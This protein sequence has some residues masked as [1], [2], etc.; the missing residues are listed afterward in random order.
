MMTFIDGSLWRRVSVG[1]ALVLA[2]GGLVP[3]SAAVASDAV[4]PV[5]VDA[6]AGSTGLSVYD[7]SQGHS[8]TVTVTA[9]QPGTCLR[10][11]RL[12]RIGGSTTIT[13][14]AGKPLVRTGS[15]LLDA[16]Y[17]LAVQEAG[18]DSTEHVT[19]GDY[20]NGADMD[21][22]ADGTGCF[23]TGKNWT[24]I[25]TRD[26]SYSA[27]LG[28]SALDPVRM[29][30]TLE[31]R[32]SDR[33]TGWYDEA[34]DPQILQDSGTGGGYPNSTD[35]VSWATGAA[36]V[37]N[38]LPD[39]YRDAFAATSYTALSNTIDH[40]RQVVFDT[41]NQLYSG[42][43]SFLDWRW[44]TYPSWIGLDMTQIAQSMSLS[45]NVTHWIAIDQAATL[46]ARAGDAAKATRYRTWADDLAEAIRT[47]FWLPE[48]GQFSA[49]V[50]GTLDPA[51]TER[52]DA[53]GTALVILSG[54][55]TPQQAAQA[56]ASY[57]QTSS[58]APV[59]WPQQSSIW[60]NRSQLSYHNNAAWPFVTAFLLEAAAKVGNDTAAS[61][62]V[63]ALVRTPA[64]YGSNYE[65]VNIVGGGLNTDTNS[66]RQL[67]SVAG[68]LGSFQKT[69]F[70]VDASA[71]GLTVEPYLTAQTRQKY[72]PDSDKI[73]LEGLS[74][75]GRTVDVEVALPG[76]AATAGSYQVTGLTVNG[77]AV[78]P[79]AVISPAALGA[80]GAHATVAVTLGAPTAS[81]PATATAAVEVGNQEAQYGPDVPTVSTVTA[82]SATT[83]NLG[84]DLGGNSPSQVSMDVLRDGTVIADDVPASTGYADTTA[85][86]MASHSYCYSVRLTYRSSGNTSQPAKATC[87]WGPGGERILVADSSEFVDKVGGEWSDKTINGVTH[88]YVKDW[89]NGLNDSLTSRLTATKTG[90]YLAQVSYAVSANPDVRLGV[91]SGIKMLSVYDEA[92]GDLIT[93]KPVVMPNTGDWSTINKSTFVPVDLVGGR[94]YRLVVSSDKL[95]VNM[96]YFQANSVY[97]TSAEN[98]NS[99]PKNANDIFEMRLLLKDVPDL[100]VTARGPAALTSG[101]V[102]SGTLATVTGGLAADAS[103]LSATV[104]W[105]D[106]SSDTGVVTSDGFG[107]FTISGGHRFTTPGTFEVVLSL[108]DGQQTRTGTFAV[109]VS[110]SGIVASTPAIT[111]TAQVGKVLRVVTGTWSPAVT[112]TYQ[113]RAD[114]VVIPGARSASL[115]LRAAQA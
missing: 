44:Q 94:E 115:S 1:C 51:P 24:S 34:P 74:Y 13:E 46:A 8:G 38:W 82:A 45:T 11:Y 16:L 111:G 7:D 52:Y 31:F 71:D 68:M 104:A 20:N 36:E 58:G 84:I 72:F 2:A 27:A 92:T 37:L 113:W 93:R 10:T 28:L 49:L 33:R 63:D 65:N 40:D 54:I 91:S 67:W 60:D 43:S 59:I 88:H 41:Q 62:Q 9:T 35:R 87:Y 107:T 95:A 32:L 39:E 5:T 70:G 78:Q 48:R 61:R 15:S 21:C 79:G 66:E 6:C 85:S 42:E 101:A 22:T 89:G 97:R 86:G 53:L 83:I 18:Q 103:G 76:S 55:A 4:V 47:R 14:G 96:G 114:G 23:Y 98:L 99:A 105:G 17:A 109:T 80:E 69:M 100:A 57:P 50:T 75:R 3:A 19:H 25:W 112:L 81:V 108:S 110:R 73:V 26:V 90:S 56:I 30:N 64:L 29:R 106:G 102:V 12:D 77:Q